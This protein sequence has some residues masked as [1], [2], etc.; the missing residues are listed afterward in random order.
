ML[1]RQIHREIGLYD[2]AM[3]C[4][5]DREMFA[6]IFNHG[7]KI[8]TV[9]KPVV[10]YRCHTKQMH[11]SERKLRYNVQLQKECKAA[12]QKRKT[13]LSGLEML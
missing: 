1:K 8:G 4:K 5:S 2:E 13:D 11:K 6:R 9:K 7:Y 12:I 10:L 3:W